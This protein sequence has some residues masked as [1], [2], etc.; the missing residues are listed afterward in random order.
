MKQSDTERP[1]RRPSRVRVVEFGKDVAGVV[2]AIFRNGKDAY[3][4]GNYSGKGPENG[5]S[6][7]SI[8]NVYLLLWEESHI[9]PGQPA[10]SKSRDRVAK[11]GD[12]KEDQIHLPVGTG[13][14]ADTGLGFED[15]D[16][17]TEEKRSGKVDG[18]GDGNVS[19]YKR[20]TADPRCDSAVGRRCQH[21]SLIVNAAA[22]GIDT[23]NLTER[24]SYAKNDE[25][26][27]EPAPDD[28]DGTGAG[29][30]VVKCCRQTVGD[31]G[32]DEGHE[33]DLESG[34]R[35]H[36]LSL[37]AHSLQEIVGIIGTVFARG[38]LLAQAQLASLL[39]RGTHVDVIL[40]GIGIRLGA[41]AI[42]GHE[43]RAATVCARKVCG[44]EGR[45]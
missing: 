4:N 3:D 28:A 12:G 9:E 35:S 21:K 17:C 8:S 39:G 44:V 30:G 16:A 45:R 26:D 23:G 36:Q 10:V 19:D 40:G 32:Q 27:T 38:V 37:V 2:A 41:I 34:A 20:P 33:G 24:G 25:R 43:G 5:K 29:N 31:R 6:L 18:E 22:G 14:D 42:V 15:I 13:E 7:F 11:E 1:P